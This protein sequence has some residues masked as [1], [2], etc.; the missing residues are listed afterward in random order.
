[1]TAAFARANGIK[2]VAVIYPFAL[3]L[4]VWWQASLHG[5]LGNAF[6]SPSPDRVWASATASSATC[7]IAP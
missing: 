2:L 7:T 4:F 6:V 5:W 1:M 3:V